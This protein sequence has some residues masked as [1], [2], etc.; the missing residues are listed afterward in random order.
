MTH[1]TEAELVRWRDQGA[2]E[3]RA[4]LLSHLAACDG[5][6]RRLAELVRLGPIAGARAHFDP[7]DF[8]A[9]GRTVARQSRAR[10]RWPAIWG[11]AAAAVAAVLI[12]ALVVVRPDPPPNASLA[13]RGGELSAMAPV[14]EVTRVDE[15][16]WASP[17]AASRYRV[18]VRDAA[19][20]T[21]LSGETAGERIPLSPDEAA[22]LAPGRYTWTIQALDGAGRTIAVSRPQSFEVQAAR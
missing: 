14:G 8:A 17:F 13:V 22:R 4:H 5:C 18:V 12:V 2:A 10:Y 9:R 3:D 19:A 6:R 20:K 16:R 11:A 1:L 7:E 15:L 21:V